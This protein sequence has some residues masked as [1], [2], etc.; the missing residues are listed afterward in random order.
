MFCGGCEY[1][2]LAM[3][4]QWL[5]C[6]HSAEDETEQLSRMRWDLLSTPDLE[7]R[8]GNSCLQN[9]GPQLC[10]EGVGEELVL[11]IH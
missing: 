4:S 8:R 11:D 5:M 1:I 2:P 7:Y 3:S 9:R 10:S 6:S